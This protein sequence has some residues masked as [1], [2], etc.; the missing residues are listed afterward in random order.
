MVLKNLL[1]VGLGALTGGLGIV[2]VFSGLG[3]FSGLPGL[4]G[5]ISGF[6]F[7]TGNSPF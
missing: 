6:F 4:P 7:A 1:T 2:G 5:V 3:G